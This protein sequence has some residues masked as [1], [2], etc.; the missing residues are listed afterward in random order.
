MGD[1]K[2]SP[3]LERTTQAT[4]GSFNDAFNRHDADALAELLTDD[5]IS[6]T[7]PL[8]QTADALIRRRRFSTIGERGSYAIL[9]QNSKRKK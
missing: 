7:P 5:T 1:K 2:H 8:R 9:T 6:R 3:E 4:I